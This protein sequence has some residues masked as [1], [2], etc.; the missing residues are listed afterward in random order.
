MTAAVGELTRTGPSI[1]LAAAIITEGAAVA[2]A[3]AAA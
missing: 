2:G 1:G 3:G